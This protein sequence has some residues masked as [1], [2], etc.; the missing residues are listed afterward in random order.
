[1]RTTSRLVVPLAAVTLAAGLAASP[2]TSS[3]PDADPPWTTV[4]T[5]LDNPRHLSVAAGAVYVAEA[6]VGG[7]GPCTEGPEGHTCF[8]TSGAITKISKGTQK[9]VLTGLPSMAGEGGASAVGPT[10]VQ[11]TGKAFTV[12]LG[13]GNDP[14]AR[15]VLPG[16]G[17]WMGTLV[18]GRFS[19]GSSKH[20]G[21]PTV[22]ADLAAHE[23]A[24][25]P[26][27][28]DPDSNP[29]GLVRVG[30]KAY[31]VD[32]GG[33][34]LLKV[35]RAGHVSTVM[36]F[37]SPGTGVPPLPPVPMQAVPTS[38]VKG[39]DGALYVSEL[40]G[41]PFVPGAARIHR[42]ARN[43]SHSIY[44][45]GLT[46]VTDLAW[47]KGSLY[48]VQ[49][50]DDGLLAGGEGLPMGSL[51]K[52]STTGSHTTVAADLPAPYGVAFNRHTAYVTTCTVCPGGGSVVAVGMP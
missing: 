24:Y 51:V 16:N 45:T 39:D 36:A 34:T 20:S 28:V 25:N 15:E 4:A 17:A 6:G 31:V 49:L 29:G 21:T 35:D 19:H 40:T 26:D 23:A 7:S 30:S 41:F 46:N 2:A 1:M 43:G 8:G 9:R 13:L 3:P 52:V 44:A 47:Y 14:A 27:G 33:N 32:A 18:T 50:A 37:D 22:W 12:S 5:G 38:V 42:I 48:A 11:V 10:D